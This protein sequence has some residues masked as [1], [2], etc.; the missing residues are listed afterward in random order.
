MRTHCEVH[1]EMQISALTTH[2]ILVC[3]SRA[4]E[5]D[6]PREGHSKQNDPHFVLMASR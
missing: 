4:S 2:H 6:S 1:Q 5:L 3:C